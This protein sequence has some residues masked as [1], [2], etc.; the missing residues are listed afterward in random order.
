MRNMML[1]I[2]LALGIVAHA[3]EKAPASWRE[4]ATGMEFVQISKGCFQMGNRKAVAFREEFSGL[5]LSYHDSPFNDELPQHEACVDA[6]WMGRFEVRTEEWQ[7]VMG[8]QVQ[9]P[10]T[11]VANV[12]WKQAVTFAQKLSERSGGKYRYRLPTEAE[13]EYACRAGAASE[14]VPSQGELADRAWYGVEPDGLKGETQSTGKLAANA[15]GLH[16]M[17]GN[18]WEWVQDSYQSNAYASHGLY[19]P[20]VQAQGANKV[21]RGA[22]YRSQPLHVRCAKRSHY[23]AAQGTGTIGLRLVR[24]P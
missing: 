24:T 12:T 14:I 6:F 8:G 15:F 20:V 16:D 7:R 11:P 5:P 22:S 2:G 21:I 17:L 9:R 18:V 10:G 3:A 1:I 23:S 19:N 13:W 4:P